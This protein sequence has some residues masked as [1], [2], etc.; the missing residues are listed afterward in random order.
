M[1]RYLILAFK[2]LKRRGIR[3]WL[4][5]LGIFI[6][7]ASVVALIGLG[8]ALKE[9][10]NSQFDIGSTD[11]I[12]IQAGGLNSYGPPGSGAVNPLTTND[13]EEIKNIPLIKLAIGRN[14]ETLK[15]VFNKKTVFSYLV[16]LPDDDTKY[17]LY[18]IQDLS[19]VQGRFIQSGD[20]NA[21]LLGNDFLDK[22]KNGFEKSIKPSDKIEIQGESF[23]VVGI[24]EKK[25]SF[26]IDQMILMQDKDLKKIKDND[27]ELDIIVALVKSKE[28]IELAKQDIEKI[29]RKTRRV[30]EGEED[31]QVSTPQAALST[32]NQVILGVQIFIVLI[33]SVSIIVGSIGVS[34]TMYASVLER[35]RE[36][37]TMKAIGARNSHIFW[38]FFVESGLLGFVGGILGIIAGVIISYIGVYSL[39]NFLGTI[40]KVSLDWTLFSLVLFFSFLIG[41]I[42]GILP[43]MRAAKLNPV[44][45]LRE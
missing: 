12:S 2:N 26:T 15:S 44:E 21:I 35:K 31:F 24:L 37:G 41:S 42:S 13:L 20:E 30:K 25:G 18:E 17:D 39:N 36:I 40:T 34:N 14:I 22:D 3:S 38:Q 23:K 11:I 4:T 7:I 32:V 28:N 9:T 6:G 10:V 5:L 29:L 45:A 27:D 33:A 8:T 1:K 43:A 19:I 16:T